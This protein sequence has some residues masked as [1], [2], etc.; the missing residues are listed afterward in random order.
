MLPLWGLDFSPTKYFVL[1]DFRP[2]MENHK[3]TTSITAICS[4][5]G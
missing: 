5:A 2:V 4:V 1:S 3:T